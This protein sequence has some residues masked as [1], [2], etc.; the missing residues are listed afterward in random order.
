M[1]GSAPTENAYAAHDGQDD[2][3][4]PLSACIEGSW[5][6]VMSMIQGC[7]QAEVASHRRVVTTIIVIEDGRDH[8]YGMKQHIPTGRMQLTPVEQFM[9]RI[10]VSVHQ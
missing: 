9:R 8:S 1:D 3:W 4:E 6:R 7:H 2:A 5:D 10:P